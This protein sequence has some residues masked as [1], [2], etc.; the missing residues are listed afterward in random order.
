MVEPTSMRQD[1][2]SFDERSVRAARATPTAYPRTRPLRRP[3]R[4]MNAES[5][6]ENS[7]A[8]R[9][10]TELGTPAQV[11]DPRMLAARIVATASEAAVAPLP[12]IWLANSSHV[13]RRRIRASS[14]PV[15]GRSE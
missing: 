14:R 8:P 6:M 15:V 7:A 12:K 2:D 3:K 10:R 1:L 11:L 4:A 13:V 5:G 9:V